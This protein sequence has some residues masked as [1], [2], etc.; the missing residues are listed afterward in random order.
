MKEYDW[1]ADS[2]V[3]ICGQSVRSAAS[4]CPSVGW[5]GMGCALL[6][7]LI[8]ASGGRRLEVQ[9]GWSAGLRME[10]QELP[11]AGGFP[12]AGLTMA[13]LENNWMRFPLLYYSEAILL[14]L[15]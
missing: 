12:S 6:S 3:R 14:T 1:L 2:N 5:T 7:A 13:T 15:F 8:K 11:A 9:S 4:C 10:S